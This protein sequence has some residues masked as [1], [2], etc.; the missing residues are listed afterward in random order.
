MPTVP[1]LGPVASSRVNSSSLPPLLQTPSGLALL[2]IQG[3]INVPHPPLPD[4]SATSVGRLVYP[5]Y[6]SEGVENKD[7]QKT[8]H[9]YV[10]QHQRMTGEL[11]KL[12]KP[13]AV[14]RKRA[15]QNNVDELEIIEIVHHK[16]LFSSRP[17]PVS[18]SAA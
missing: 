16:L 10:G 1:L 11:K 17:E 9:L 15:S 8:V 18:G 7:W 5:L 13:I 14:I 6:G 3:T 4:S 12:S 2:E